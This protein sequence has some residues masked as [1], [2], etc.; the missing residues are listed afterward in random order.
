MPHIIDRVKTTLA[1][2]QPFPIIAVSLVQFYSPFWE[3][4]LLRWSVQSTD[5]LRHC[6]AVVENMLM[7]LGI[8]PHYPSDRSAL[9]TALEG[10]PEVSLDHHLRGMVFPHHLFVVREVVLSRIKGKREF[11]VLD[12]RAL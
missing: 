5:A 7:S 11:D 10:I 9:V 12:R 1:A 6:Q 4:T 2:V 3:T 8:T